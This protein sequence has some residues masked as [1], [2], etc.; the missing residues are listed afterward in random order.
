MDPIS[1]LNFVEAITT[2]N[3]AAG[4]SDINGATLNLDGHRA[5]TAMVKFGTIAATAV[6]SLKWQGSENNST[7]SDLEGTSI[8]VAA[9]DDNKMFITALNLPL[10]RY[11][12]IVVDRGTA[13]ATV[14]SAWYVLDR[15]AF[16]GVS[17]E[18]SSSLGSREL[19]SS[20]NF[21]TA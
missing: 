1:R 9:D 3:G 2:T 20:P 21:G 18:D 17:G 5:V 13:N 12:R 14:L 11:L 7:W 4:T 10:Q 6:T 15:A 8:T 16:T 19:H